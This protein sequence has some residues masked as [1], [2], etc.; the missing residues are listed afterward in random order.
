VALGA[1]L[2]VHQHHHG[3]RTHLPAFLAVE[4][5]QRGQ[6]EVAA[7]LAE[8]GVDLRLMVPAMATPPENIYMLLPGELT[9]FRLATRLAD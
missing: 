5:I 7:H 3:E 6:A 2:G 1:Q 4:Q 8:M 9:G